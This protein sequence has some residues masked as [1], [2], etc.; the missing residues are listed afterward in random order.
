MRKFAWMALIFLMASGA[1]YAQEAEQNPVTASVREIYN[2]HSKYIA[3]AAAEMP[4]DKYSYHPTPEQWT[5]G[6]IV[7]HVAQSDFG[8]CSM[9]SGNPAPKMQKLSETDPKDTLVTALQAS[10]DSA[11][12]RSPSCRIRRWVTPSLFSAVRRSR[13]P[14]R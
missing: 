2:R 11:T 13:V 8:V 7:S 14:G 10:F 12:R 9:I 1:A 4:A 6:K 3:A 5:F